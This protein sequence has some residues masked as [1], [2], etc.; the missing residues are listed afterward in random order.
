MSRKIFDY[1]KSVFGNLQ[2]LATDIGVDYQLLGSG[3]NYKLKIQ[4][5]ILFCF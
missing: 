2:G 1:T 3:N 4:F 5:I